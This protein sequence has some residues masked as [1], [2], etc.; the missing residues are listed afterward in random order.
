MTLQCGTASEQRRHCN[1][2][3]KNQMMSAKIMN[4]TNTTLHEG[5]Q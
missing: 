2:F 5:I 1:H 4:N 3:W